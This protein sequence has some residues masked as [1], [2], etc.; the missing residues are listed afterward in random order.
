MTNPRPSRG[1]TLVELLVVIG[2]IALLISI[3]L[4]SLTQARATANMV[5]CASNMRQLAQALVNYS[6][7]YKGKFPP[8]INSLIPAPS[9]GPTA[10]L[11]YDEDRLGQYLPK[12][13]QPSATST[14]PTIGGLVFICPSGYPGEQ[15]GYAMNIWASSQTDQS[16]LNKSPQRQTYNGPYNPNPPFRGTF[17]NSS[18]ASTELILI[19]E[20]HPRNST[21]AGFF[22]NATSGFQGDFPGQR[23]LG[24]PGYTVGASD[25]GGGLYPNSSAR[26]EIAWYKHR[27]NSDKQQGTNEF[28]R[29][30]F[31]FGDGHVES[32]APSD[33]AD[34]ETGKSRLKALWSP[35]DR[36]L[37]A[38]QP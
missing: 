25:F 26:S 27:R 24:I 14:N 1:F 21:A 3:L 35:Y 18:K 36:E 16:T 32:F 23:F 2:I 33:L 17:W 11:W 15:R 12:G 28:G 30:N 6:I 4:P 22:S 7:E 37:T 34:P 31:A 5:K 13:T 19:T 20:A 9:S 29:A 8:N 10:N 38:N